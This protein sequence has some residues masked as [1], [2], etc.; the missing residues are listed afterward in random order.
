[1]K[2]E[3]ESKGSNPKQQDEDVEMHK[4]D[5]DE[6][7]SV[8]DDEAIKDGDKQ[9]MMLRFKGIIHLA[10]QGTKGTKY[11]KGATG[12]KERSLQA[13]GTYHYWD[14][15]KTKVGSSG[16]TEKTN[17]ASSPWTGRTLIRAPQSSTPQRHS[18]YSY[19]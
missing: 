13:N 15:M 3:Q 17:V 18:V 5:T 19:H 14:A 10:T 7:S 11:K 6:G 12:T 1:M 4:D 8:E 2:E 16:S 9:K